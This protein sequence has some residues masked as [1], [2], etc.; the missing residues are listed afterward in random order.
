M[1]PNSSKARSTSA[2]GALAR[3]RDRHGPTDAA[4]GA[5]DQ[6]DLAGEAA[7]PDVGVLTMIGPRPHL[8]GQAGRRDRLLGV[9][10][11]GAGLLGSPG[12]GD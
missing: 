11:L 8:V 4:V 7:E 3:E 2:V 9:L 5:G 1:R 10:G 12:T 6:R